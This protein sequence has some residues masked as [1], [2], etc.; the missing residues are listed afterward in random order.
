VL[1]AK[2]G[3]YQSNKAADGIFKIAYDVKST[4]IS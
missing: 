3:S 1:V 2:D 4:G